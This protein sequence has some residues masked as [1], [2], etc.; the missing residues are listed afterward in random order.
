[1]C[2]V[3]LGCMKLRVVPPVVSRNPG[4]NM[5]EKLHCTRSP[6]K[7]GYGWDPRSLGLKLRK[8]KC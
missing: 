7:P 5:K 3:G 2:A 1:M 8:E 4:E 6:N